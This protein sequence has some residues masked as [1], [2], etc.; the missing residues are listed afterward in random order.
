MS[1]QKTKKNVD[2]FIGFKLGDLWLEFLLRQCAQML[3]VG[4]G[5]STRVKF[6]AQV[7][8]PSHLN[9]L[10]VS[11]LTLCLFSATPCS[12]LPLSAMTCWP[13]APSFVIVSCFL[14]I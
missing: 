4:I 9:F 14:L 1:S 6:T 3:A 5:L 11:G 12:Y 10:K 7:G 2:P 13:Q 8:P